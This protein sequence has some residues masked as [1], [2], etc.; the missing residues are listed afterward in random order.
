MTRP[1][2]YLSATAGTELG[3]CTAAAYGND[4]RRANTTAKAFRS[5]S[6]SRW[7]TL[8]RLLLE[9]LEATAAPEHYGHRENQQQKEA[10]SVDSKFGARLTTAA[11]LVA[12]VVIRLR[13]YI[14]N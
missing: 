1:G 2:A 3:R 13:T 7:L 10:P 5:I 6:C 4:V 12:A 11:N 8:E 9:R 14:S